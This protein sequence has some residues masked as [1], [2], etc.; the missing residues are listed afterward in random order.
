MSSADSSRT[1]T[2]YHHGDLPSTLLAAVGDV[3]AQGGPDT[4]SLREVARRAGV[5][6]G[7]PA[8]HFGDA[9]GLLTAYVR[10]AFLDLAATLQA[11]RVEGGELARLK[12]LGM[13]YV[14][15]ALA[16]PARYQLMF[17]RQR[18]D[19]DD[20][21]L[22]QAAEQA[23]LPLAQCVATLTKTPHSRAAD[24]PYLL[25]AWSSVHGFAML[26]LEGIPAVL[27]HSDNQ[28]RAQLGQMLDT[29]LASWPS[30]ES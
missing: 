11:T 4:L 15:F 23:F 12:A 27:K 21:A 25:L 3:L 18:I 2:R 20:C 10:E 30:S 9:R 14:E 8:H 29:L 26:A 16:H 6:H 13:A 19:H 28:W 17:R 5:S 22:Q 24:N 7:A 1:P